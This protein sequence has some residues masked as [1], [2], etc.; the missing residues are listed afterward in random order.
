MHIFDKNLF[1]VTTLEIAHRISQQNGRLYLVG[2]GVRDLLLGKTPHDKDYCVTGLSSESFEALFPQAIS[3][4]KSFPVYILNGCEFALARKEKKNGKQHFDFACDVSPN[5]RI[6]DDL[7]RRDLTINSMAIDVLTQ[8]LIDPFHG[9]DDLQ[10][11]RLKMT[12]SAFQ[13]DPLRVYRVARFAA[14]FSF[15]VDE[16]TLKMMSSMKEDL[17]YLSVE[18]VFQE[19][20]KALVNQ[21][22]S[23]FF[24][25]LRM[26]NC[27]DIHFPEIHHLIGVEQPL[28]YHPEGDAFQ[29]TMDVLERVALQS[30]DELTRFGALVHDFGKTV[31]PRENWPHHY[32]H[33]KLGIPVVRDFCNRLK[34]PS[35]FLKAGCTACREH[36]LA[37][38]YPHLKPGTKV[39]FLERVFKAKFLS[40]EGL[41]LIANC[42]TQKSPPIQFAKAGHYIMSDI[43]F[44][45][46]DRLKLKSKNDFEKI[47]Q[48]LHEKRIRALKNFEKE[49]I[50]NLNKI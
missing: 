15:S 27:L 42:D 23:H 47:H 1:E 19:F 25:T 6:E 30:S 33:E 43:A 2:G 10:N 16:D 21:S 32:Q 11:K 38:N 4:G 46:E 34:M 3:Q 7:Q 36:M 45:E 17:Q 50:P 9:K 35:S 13:E 29:H 24:W 8:E 49:E 26:A 44:S 18:R 37:G 40:L 28:L 20:R 48:I 5:L 12:S 22:P 14:Q 39:N 41:E 31:T